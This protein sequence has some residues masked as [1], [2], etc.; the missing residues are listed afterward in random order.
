MR[1]RSI[2]LFSVLLIVASCK[3]KNGETTKLGK[4]YHNITGRYNAYYNAGLLLDKGFVAANQS[5]KDNYNQIIPMFPYAPA[6]LS[7][8]EKQTISNQA[9]K[10]ADKEKTVDKSLPNA[11]NANASAG[12][13]N[14]LDDAIKK[15]A[16]NIELHRPS[17]WVDDS[18]FIVGK[19][20]FLK[21]DFEKAAS[22]FKYIVDKFNTEKALNEMSPDELKA[23]KK[24]EEEKN[25]NKKKKKKKSYKKKKK[26]A[27]KKSSSQ[28]DESKDSKTATNSKNT[29]EEEEQK[30]TSYFLKH[31][32]VRYEA[33][34]WL[35]KSY[36]EIRNFDEAERLLRLL[37]EKGDVAKKIKADAHA[38]M[39]HSYLR[40]K[41]WAKAVEPL[42]QAISLTKSKKKKNRWVYILAQLYQKAGDNAKS[43]AYF[44]S[45]LKLKP[46]YEM[47][48]N[49]RLNM[50][51]NAAGT[52]SKWNP[53]LALKRML[54]EGK[55][56]EYKDQIYFALAQVQLRAGAKEKGIEALLQAMQ[57]SDG[58]Q[59]AEASYLLAELY[60]EKEMYVN[61][62][63]YYDTCTNNLDKSDERAFYVNNQKSLL[64][65]LA[66]HLE[67]TGLKDSLLAI[68]NWSID[69][70]KQ[71]VQKYKEEED[72]QKANNKNSSPK[73]ATDGLV[74]GNKVA[75]SK[76]ALYDPNVVKRG[77]KD[78]QKRWGNRE[79]ADQWRRAST[80]KN[81]SDD[82]NSSSS[83]PMTESELKDYLKKLGVPL[84]SAAQNAMKKDIEK[85]I[86]MTGTLFYEKLEKNR[87]AQLYLKKL[88]DRFPQTTHKLEA[89]F[90]L[91]NICLDEK[92]SCSQTYKDQIL[93]EY[94]SSDIAKS[95]EDPNFLNT[96]Q[97]LVKEVNDY[98]DATYVLIKKSNFLEAK[99]NLDDLVKKF[100]AQYPMKAKFALLAAMCKGGIDGIEEYIKAL[101]QISS[102]FPNTD[103]DKRA[104]EMVVILSGMKENVKTQEL[105][106]T[107]EDKPKAQFENDMQVGHYVMVTFNL[108][109]TNTNDLKSVITDF[110]N[111]YYNLMRLNVSSLMLDGNI[112]TLIVRKFKDGKDAA[113]YLKAA[114]GKE[115]FLGKNP[116]QHR[117]YFIGQNN[118]REVLQK[119]NFAE[120]IQFFEQTYRN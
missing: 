71:F 59:Q 18:Y 78:F 38:V 43:L 114:M 49:A 88:F 6:E 90:T 100:G 52:G 119:R 45:V 3:N 32:P 34:L 16:T 108:D 86:F 93:N 81:S 31:R 13:G 104:K 4:F 62:Y 111:K 23:Y 89:L 28:K 56:E 15:C 92:N 21:K 41:E 80:E 19:A 2:L 1:I 110:N 61:A 29:E 5:H 8:A 14:P 64:K 24:K 109:N 27:K 115:D 117:L 48:F 26:P 85:S 39:A 36:I 99:K 47:E 83:G 35:A 9:T 113:D 112:P 65:D 74:N 10:P 116:P 87:T 118:Y 42:E 46:T 37:I 96:K 103:E 107:V 73:P 82:Q 95:L 30:P 51:L 66:F 12:S 44:K 91:Y 55:N 17:H 67:N 75:E 40:K 7:R 25:S 63:H 11:N 105:V 22:T 94:P 69:K 77:E 97:R 120:Y 72:K 102:A 20:E 101:R 60:F 33:M 54:K 68:S 84:D 98:Y 106:E 79:W 76:Y 57:N 53:E 50:A 58:F 70:Q